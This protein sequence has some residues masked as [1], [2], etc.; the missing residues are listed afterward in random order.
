MLT[1][2]I[3]ISAIFLF[4][5][6]IEIPCDAQ[7]SS[8]DLDTILNHN[9]VKPD[10]TYK[11]KF[12]FIPNKKIIKYNPISLAFGGMMFFYQKIISPQIASECPYEISCSNFSKA[13]ITRY[14]LIKGIALTSYRL[15]RCNRLAA[16]DVH[17]LYINPAGKIIDDPEQ[18]KLK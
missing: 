2:Y 10:V 7:N 16:I 4:I 11:P 3:K 1:T 14:G 6:R 18:Y 17:P 9:F 13:V 5:L 15:M 12:L 8:A